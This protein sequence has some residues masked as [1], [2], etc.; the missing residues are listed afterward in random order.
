MCNYLAR[1]WSPEGGCHICSEETRDLS[2]TPDSELPIVQ[3]TIF[4][5]QPIPFLEV[6]FERIAKLNYPKD[7]MHLTTHCL[8]EKQQKFV[9]DFTT[10]HGSSYRSVNL[11]DAKIFNS[12]R[13]AFVEAASSCLKEETCDYLF[14]VDGTVQFTDP[15]VLRHLMAANR[16]VIAPMMTRR[17]KFWSSF[18]GDVSE[19]G[20]Y[21]RSNDY[22]SIVERTKM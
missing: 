20:G 8:V 19:D 2:K 21:I 17:G 4:I 22:F 6:F 18:W 9:D 7:R 1:A 15:D 10:T 16:S 3:L 13:T 12:E 5:T 11:I 14:Y